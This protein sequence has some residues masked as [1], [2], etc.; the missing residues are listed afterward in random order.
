M[1]S[2]VILVNANAENKKLV[3]CRLITSKTTECKPY[4]SKFMYT[5]KLSLERDFDDRGSDRLII[6]KR[7]PPLPK[8]KLLKVVSVEDMIENHYKVLDSVRFSGSQPSPLIEQMDEE[9]QVKEEKREREEMLA[10]L[11]LLKLKKERFELQKEQQL[12]AKLKKERLLLEDKILG[13]KEAVEKTIS[14]IEA[15]KKM[16]SIAQKEQLK[17]QIEALKQATLTRESVEKTISEI[18]A[19]KK[20]A[21]IAQKEKLKIQIEALKKATQEKEKLAQEERAAKQRLAEYEKAQRVKKYGK[22]TIESGDSLNYIAGI[23]DIRTKQI[24]D[25]NSELEHNSTLKIKQKIIIPL[26]QYRIDLAV[27]KQK[28]D[29]KQSKL[30][31]KLEKKY[32]YLNKRVRNKI[33]NEYDKKLVKTIKSKH[34][35]RV[36]ATAY[37]S[38]R[39]QTDSTPFLAAWNNRIRPGMKIIAVSRDLITKYGLGNGKKVRIHGLPGYYTVRDKMNKRYTKRIDIYM[40]TNR[41]K[42]LRWGRRKTV[43]YW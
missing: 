37:S 6:S 39:G 29:T 27:G 8:P 28:K 2:I 32:Q 31:K 5:A 4:P 30:T 1:S 12:E 41:R 19:R 20:M 23:F 35:L 21:S 11:E 9:K 33:I 17:I 42:A 10:A 14:E 40:G 36:Q 13:K 18:E 38:H 7:L 24:L 26:S 3:D 22:Y 34:S 15:R 25:V 16:Q 43:I